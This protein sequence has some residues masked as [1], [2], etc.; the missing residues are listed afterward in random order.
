MKNGLPTLTGIAAVIT[1][2]GGV[3]TIFHPKPELKST[4][5][6]SPKTPEA[7]NFRVFNRLGTG[8]VS[9]RVVLL[10]DGK[11]VGT[12]TVDAFHTEAMMEI[13]VPESGRYSYTAE[14]TAVF[15]VNGTPITY[16]GAGQGTIQVK[17]GKN[18][19]LTG[20]ISGNTWYIS[21]VDITR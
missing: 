9:E 11:V 10:L 1:A 18:F 8:E 5:T 12:L 4:P 14:S 3:L 6:P 16:V 19:E 7:A 15:N 17:S 13:T 2:I 20:S 21:L